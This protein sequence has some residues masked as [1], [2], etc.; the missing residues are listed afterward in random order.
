MSHFLL[1]VEMVAYNLRN[2]AI[3]HYSH[4]SNL[5][6]RSMSMKKYG[7]RYICIALIKTW[8]NGLFGLKA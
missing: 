4:I 3:S 8:Q 6:N 7:V 1:M 2:F 5:I